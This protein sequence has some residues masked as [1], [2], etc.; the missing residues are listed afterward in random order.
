MTSECDQINPHLS[1]ILCQGWAMTWTLAWVTQGYL[2]TKWVASS[3]PN[4]SGLAT[5]CCLASTYTVFF[6]LS[7]AMMSELSPVS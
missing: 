2:D 7:V 4:S 3:S 6:W 5:P 1:G